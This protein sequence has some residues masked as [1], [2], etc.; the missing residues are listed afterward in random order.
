MANSR[1]GEFAGRAAVVLG[2]SSGFGFG[3][4]RYLR[5]EG[6]SVL[7]AAR[8][9]P[10]LEKAAADLDCEFLCCDGSVDEQIEQLAAHALQRFGRLDIAVN[11]AGYEDSAAIRDL[12]PERLEPMVAVQFTGALYFIRHMANAMEGPGSIICLSSLTATLVAEGYAAY[13]GAKA[14]LNHAV[15]IAASEYGSSGIRINCVSPSIIE[16]PMTA[17]IFAVP[18]IVDA[19][20]EETPLGRI[21]QVEDVVEAV[22]WL[23]SD[24]SSY[25][26]GQNIH[27]DGGNS[28]RRLPGPADIMRHL[29][30]RAAKE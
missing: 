13:A 15:R 21:G 4:S 19:F 25:I 27:V 7:I 5:S 30:A 16:T 23:A 3:I 12:T 20:L 28:L 8:R 9:R 6:A 26:T 10:E 2:G 1:G 14:G 22:A 17:K 18:G 24:R 29:S 11:C